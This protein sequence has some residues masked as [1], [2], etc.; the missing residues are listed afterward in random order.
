ML[1]VRVS[2]PLQHAGVCTKQL[3]LILSHRVCVNGMEVTESVCFTHTYTCTNVNPTHSYYKFR[4]Q[5]S[6]L[7]VLHSFSL[8]LSLQ[9]TFLCFPMQSTCLYVDGA[10]L[11]VHNGT[12]RADNSPAPRQLL[13]HRHRQTSEW[14]SLLCARVC[15]HHASVRDNMIDWMLVPI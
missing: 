9:D 4:A 6:N 11:V 5:I 10:L 1:E 3:V 2:M 8:H 12:R 7:F 13:H 15:T 14:W